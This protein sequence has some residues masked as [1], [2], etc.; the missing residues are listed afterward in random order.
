MEKKKRSRFAFSNSDLNGYES[1]FAKGGD[2]LKIAKKI[3]CLLKKTRNPKAIID[4][5]DIV[6]KN[7]NL[8][9]Y[10]FNS[11]YELLQRMKKDGHFSSLQKVQRE[12]KKITSVKTF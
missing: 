9:G 3:D 8:I 10:M 11:I 2:A 6:L 4:A 12:T 1:L 5:M 7:E